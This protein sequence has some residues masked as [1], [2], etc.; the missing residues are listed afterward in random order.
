VLKVSFELELTQI[1]LIK[2]SSFNKTET[3]W[4]RWQDV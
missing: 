2:S 3:Q 4:T 1:K